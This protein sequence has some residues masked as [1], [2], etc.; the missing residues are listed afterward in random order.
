M[1]PCACGSELPRRELRDARGIFCTFVCDACEAGRRE[2]FR[3]EVLAD[4]QYPAD[5]LGDDGE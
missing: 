4:P 2:L 1:R 5:D 3:P